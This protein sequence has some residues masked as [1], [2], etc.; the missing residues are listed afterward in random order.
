MSYQLIT[1]PF[2]AIS[3][4]HKSLLERPKKE[5]TQYPHPSITSIVENSRDTP[6]EHE[7]CDCVQGESTKTYPEMSGNLMRVFEYDIL[8]SATFPVPNPV[9]PL[10][11]ESGKQD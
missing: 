10:R 1:Q 6:A 5:G 3:G 9:E 8:K 2:L 11:R 7:Q 4:T